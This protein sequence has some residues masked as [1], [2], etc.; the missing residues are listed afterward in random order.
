[1]NTLDQPNQPVHIGI[2]VAKATLQIDLLGKSRK[3]PNTAAGHEALLGLLPWNA[4]IIMESTGSYHLAPLACFQTAGIPVAIVNPVRVKQFG[5]ARGTLAK[6]DPVDAALLTDFGRAFLPRPTPPRDPERVLLG[7]L[8]N[9]RETLGTQITL[10]NN[11]IEHQQS[12]V[13][14]KLSEAQARAAAKAMADVEARIAKLIKDSKTLAPAADVLRESQGVGAVTAAVLLAEMPELGHLNRREAAA[15][16]GVAPCANDSGKHEGKRFIRGGRPRVKRAL[17]LASL[18]AVRHH[19]TLSPAYKAL[20]AAG[21]PAKVA[22]IA[23]ARKLVVILNAQ[24]KEHYATLA[25]P[26]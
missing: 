10:W 24:L 18:S 4:F 26:A 12:A 2:D 13:A 19:P 6:T 14:R 20:R 21:K 22:L 15:L 8:V 23:I 5:K 25:Q 16:A 3:L 7:E 9:L 1:M 11:L 17:Y